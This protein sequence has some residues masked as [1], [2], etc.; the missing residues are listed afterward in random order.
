L[1][2][3]DRE[4]Y[5]GRIFVNLGSPKGER[6]LDEVLVDSSFT[7]K[8]MPAVYAQIKKQVPD[9]LAVL[10]N[11]TP[12]TG[13]FTNVLSLAFQ[14]NNPSIF[15]F[16]LKIFLRKRVKKKLRLY[17]TYGDVM[18]AQQILYQACKKDCKVYDLLKAL[19]DDAG[20]PYKT[21]FGK[22]YF[23]HYIAKVLSP[24][25]CIK[26]CTKLVE[27][28]I[29][30]G[31]TLNDKKQVPAIFSACV[32]G[33]LKML[34]VLL[35]H[36]TVKSLNVSYK[37]CTPLT[38]LPIHSKKLGNA[39]IMKAVKSLIAAG[40][41]PTFCPEEGVTLWEAAVK[42]KNWELAQFLVK[43][44]YNGPSDL[45]ERDL[46]IFSKIF[47][48]EEIY[49]LQDVIELLNVITMF[50]KGV[51]SALCFSKDPLTKEFA[52]TLLKLQDYFKENK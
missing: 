29:S 9:M 42:Y 47:Q 21:A 18:S 12:Y 44:K 24:D 33:K 36:S 51:F 15:L 16:L 2:Y 35:K 10:Y 27:F 34:P 46:A 5:A 52:I 41:D 45:L 11:G 40:A 1:S 25:I 3:R 13:R 37:K 43:K 30:K 32:Q 20:L 38:L 26:E 7:E 19:I 50:P 28:L 48:K 17:N 6:S 23:I 8:T 49:T 22:N 14:N 4:E 39:T 31:Y